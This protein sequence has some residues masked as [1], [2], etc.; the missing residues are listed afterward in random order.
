MIRIT[1]GCIFRTGNSLQNQKFVAFQKPETF[2]STGV[3]REIIRRGNDTVIVDVT[4]ASFRRLKKN[5][6]IIIKGNELKFEVKLLTWNERL[7][8]IRLNKK[9]NI[10]YWINSDIFNCSTETHTFIID[11]NAKMTTTRSYW[12][13]DVQV[14]R[15]RS[16]GRGS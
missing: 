12:E 14:I 15:G 5:K 1:C 6:T 4:S 11:I 16:N 2:D 13:L 8:P 10:Y 9:I 3:A 7:H